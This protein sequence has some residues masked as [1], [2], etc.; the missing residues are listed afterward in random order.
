M[1]SGH[2]LEIALRLFKALGRSAESWLAIQD[3]YEL[4]QARKRVKLGSV[5]KVNICRITQRCSQA[6]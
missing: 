5:Q 2:S 6:K 4:W 3:V 1:R